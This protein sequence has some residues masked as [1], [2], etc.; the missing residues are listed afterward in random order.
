MNGKIAASLMCA[1]I[2]NLERDLRLMEANGI[3]MLHCD[4]M[5]GHFVPNYMMFPDQI[6]AIARNTPLPLDI[7]IMA[8]T[9]DRVI[10]M[11]NLRQGDYVSVHAESTAHIQRAVAMIREKGG[12]PALAL[13]PATPLCMA[14]EMLPEIDMLLIM[15]VNPGFAGQKLVPGGLRKLARARA[16]LN[17]QGFSGILVEADGNCS[18]DNTPKMLSAGADIIVAGT[19]SIFD[20]ALGIE[21]GTRMLR[22]AMAFVPS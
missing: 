11:L 19:S 6:N 4:V 5:D 7:H 9:P 16:W 17:E 10:A 21:Q 22:K 12:K 13:N 1:D 15:T 8:E 14:E 18:L 20:K 3:D 2:M